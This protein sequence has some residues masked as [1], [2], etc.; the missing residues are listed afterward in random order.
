[1]CGI[2]GI[3]GQNVDPLPSLKYDSSDETQGA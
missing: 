2:A 3:V 1:M